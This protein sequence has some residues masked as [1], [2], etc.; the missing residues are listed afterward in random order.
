[1]PLTLVSVNIERSKHLDRVLPFVERERPDILCLQ[2]VVERDLSMIGSTLSAV[3][4]RYA[5]VSEYPAEVEYAV[6]GVAIFSRLPILRSSIDYYRGS[7]ESVAAMR[8]D[9]S[10]SP[11]DPAY[12][13]NCPLIRATVAKD[14]AEFS[15]ATTHFTWSAAG[16]PTD[17]QRRD[18]SRL[19]ALLE[20]DRSVVLCGDFNAP[21]GGEIFARLASIYTDN[22]PP[23][24]S[25]SIDG[26]LHRA[27]PLPYMV[28]GLFT[29]PEYV[30]KDVRLVNGVSD[31][32]AI[33]ATIEKGTAVA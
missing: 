23:E 3:D 11:I 17:E 13:M 4:Y 29:T 25:T 26:D 9:A 32:M 7:K 18:M 12:D 24:Y 27:G 21:R 8:I 16:L 10:G 22:I 33:V 31:H 19:I 30:A 14:G 5:P 28:D 1:M 2:E 15:I 20:R 6:E